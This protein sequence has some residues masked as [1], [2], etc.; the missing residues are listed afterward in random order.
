MP[1]QDAIQVSE[2][3]AHLPQIGLCLAGEAGWSEEH[4]N[5]DS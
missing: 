3:V 1:R 2:L 5:G 4:L